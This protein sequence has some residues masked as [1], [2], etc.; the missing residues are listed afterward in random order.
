MLGTLKLLVCIVQ[1]Y[2]LYSVVLSFIVVYDKLYN[3]DIIYET[4]GNAK[5][6][7]RQF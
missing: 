4:K 3:S 1:F 5:L 2:P 7:Q 6:Y